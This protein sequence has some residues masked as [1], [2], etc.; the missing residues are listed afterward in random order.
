[1]TGSFLLEQLQN[2][3]KAAGGKATFAFGAT[4]FT[5]A[6]KAEV[7]IWPSGSIVKQVPGCTQELLTRHRSNHAS[8]HA[9]LTYMSLYMTHD[10]DTFKTKPHSIDCSKM[11]L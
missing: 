11:N 4:A 6:L 8:L 3:D 5:I 7:S 2:L 9:T 10:A 1:M